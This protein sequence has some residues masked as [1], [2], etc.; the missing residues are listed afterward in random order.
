AGGTTEPRDPLDWF[1]QRFGPVVEPPLLDKARALLDGLGELP[2]AVEHRDCSPWNILITSGGE[3]V[4]LD[5]ESA[6]P[7]GLPGLDLVYFLANCAFVLDKALESGRTRESYASLLDPA[8]PNGRVAAAAIAAY[9]DALGISAEDF[10][11]LRL[12]TWIVHSRSDYRHLQLESPGE[13]TPEALR[14]APFLGLV[15]EDLSRA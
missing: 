1:A 14:N 10:R 11:R 5:W 8:T 9:T 7:A 4:L 12:L 2:P 6:E 15:E 13:P 3:P